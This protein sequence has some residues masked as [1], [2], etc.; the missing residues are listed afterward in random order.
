MIKTATI[1]SLHEQWIAAFNAHDLDRHM[2]LY[3]ADALLFG[4]VDELKKGREAIR[5]Y[6]QGRGP[7]VHVKSYPMP[8][9]IHLSE[10]VAIAAG[11]VDFA[12]GL[13]PLPYRLTWTLVKE[14]NNWRIAQHHGSPRRE[15]PE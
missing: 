6:F 13:L 2:E 8:L 9:V 7:E 5:R 14:N 11:H 4:S 10:D 12:D 3:T 1:E 15:L